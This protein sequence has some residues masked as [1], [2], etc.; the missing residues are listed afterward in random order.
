MYRP[1]IGLLYVFVDYSKAFDCVDHPTL[2]DIM[3]EMCIP[4]HVEL[5]IR[6]LHANQEANVRT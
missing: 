3:E 1:Y 4:E 6:S 2:W 5:V